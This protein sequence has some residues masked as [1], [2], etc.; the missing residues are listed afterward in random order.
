MNFTTAAS[1]DF[2]KTCF[3]RIEEIHI[4][5]FG[6]VREGGRERAF[7][8]SVYFQFEV[9]YLEQRHTSGALK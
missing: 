9:L 3:I 7:Q 4:S 1:I 6:F 2:A 5:Q 8:K